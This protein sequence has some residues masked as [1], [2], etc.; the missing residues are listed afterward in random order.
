MANN[1]RH[2]TMMQRVGADIVQCVIS[3]VVKEQFE[4]LGFVDHVDK[5][6][7]PKRRRRRKTNDDYH[8]GQSS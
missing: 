5:L 6:E 3:E 4:S 1:P 2:I 8:E 7:A